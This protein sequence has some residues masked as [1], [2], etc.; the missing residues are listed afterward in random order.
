MTAQKEDSDSAGSNTLME[1][2]YLSKSVYFENFNFAVD[3]F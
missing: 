1:T 2:I 3:L